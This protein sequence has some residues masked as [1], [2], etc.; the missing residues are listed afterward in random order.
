[1]DNSTNWT[2][3]LL[4]APGQTNFTIAPQSNSSQFFRACL[5][6]DVAAADS[7]VHRQ[8]GHIAHQWDCHAALECGRSERH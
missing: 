3:H 6:P 2:Q 5:V 1:M 8:P 4:G 7:F